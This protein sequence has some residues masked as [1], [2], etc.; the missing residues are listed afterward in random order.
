MLIVPRYQ[1]FEINMDE[2][3]DE[4][5]DSFKQAFDTIICT[6]SKSNAPTSAAAAA[7]GGRAGDRDAQPAA[8]GHGRGR[9]FAGVLGKEGAYGTLFD[10]AE[11][12]DAEDEFVNGA[13]EAANDASAV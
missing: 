8:V 2:Y 9:V 5:I 12:E 6:W 11:E 10:G 1:M 13:H 3:L 4:E 7:S